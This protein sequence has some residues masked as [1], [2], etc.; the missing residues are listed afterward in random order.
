MKKRTLTRKVKRAPETNYIPSVG[1]EKLSN[2]A[3]NMGISRQAVSQTLRRGLKKFY[4]GVQ[5]LDTSWTPFQVA[6]V[7]AKML[8][9]DQSIKDLKAFIQMLPSDVK[10]L[11]IADAVKN[12]PKV[13]EA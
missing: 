4:F 5:G 11:V 13:K 3:K 6:T 9:Q 7:M 2:I 1:D 12:A 8:H 10:K